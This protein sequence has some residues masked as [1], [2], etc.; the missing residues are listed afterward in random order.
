MKDSFQ[1]RAPQ[2]KK[3]SSEPRTTRSKKKAE[4]ADEQSVQNLLPIQPEIEEVVSQ[5]IISAF[6]ERIDKPVQDEQA[7]VVEENRTTTGSCRRN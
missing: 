5:P 3:S 1:K 7:A 6:S 4:S 2:V